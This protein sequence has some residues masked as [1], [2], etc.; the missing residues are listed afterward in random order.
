MSGTFSLYVSE[1][2]ECWELPSPNLEN[3]LLKSL[4]TFYTW[5]KDLFSVYVCTYVCTCSLN[6][7]LKTSKSPWRL[8][9]VPWN[10][11]L[12]D[13]PPLRILRNLVINQSLKGNRTTCEMEA[14][15]LLYGEPLRSPPSSIGISL[16]G[17]R[18]IRTVWLRD[19]PNP[20]KSPRL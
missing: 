8:Q 7:L 9:I 13:G 15:F 4:Y 20:L 14:V 17:R 16:S 3:M 2:T 1:R 18:L 19:G 5:S 6:R 12:K 11:F 10:H